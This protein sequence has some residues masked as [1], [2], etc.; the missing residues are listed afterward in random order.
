MRVSKRN[1]IFLFAL[2]ALWRLFPYKL[3]YAQFVVVAFLPLQASK[4]T[5][6][7]KKP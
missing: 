4:N 1:F 2:S 7:I 6:R 5:P 3:S